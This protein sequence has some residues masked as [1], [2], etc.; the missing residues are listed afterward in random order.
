RNA[1]AAQ[2]PPRPGGGT[3]G[4]GASPRSSA[5]VNRAST[6][7]TNPTTA[8][9]HASTSSVWLRGP[10]EDLARG[11]R[12]LI[13]A[14]ASVCR[15]GVSRRQQKPPPRENRGGGGLLGED[16]WERLALGGLFG[17]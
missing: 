12:L 6:T 14:G 13:A 11:S 16:R 15:W 17:G 5:L 4:R 10:T 3:S 1:A 7:T 8:P 2:M 9:S